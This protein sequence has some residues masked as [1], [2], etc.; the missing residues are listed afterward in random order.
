MPVLADANRRPR[1]VFEPG[2]HWQYGFG[3]EI[4]GA[5]VETWTGKTLREV[6]KERIIDPLG[7]IGRAHV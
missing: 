3:S 7:Q 6:F 1:T 2:T 5:L 4:T